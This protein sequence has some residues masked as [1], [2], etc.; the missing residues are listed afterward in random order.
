M[1]V[2]EPGPQINHSSKLKTQ[3]LLTD[4]FEDK[5]IKLWGKQ[6]HI[7]SHSLCS[8]HIPSNYLLLCQCAFFLSTSLAS[9]K[10]TGRWISI[11]L[12][13]EL[14]MPS[15][16]GI[17]QPSFL[18]Q[19]LDGAIVGWS[20]LVGRWVMV[21]NYPIYRREKPT[22]GKDSSHH[23]IDWL[24][25]IIS[26]F[27]LLDINFVCLDSQLRMIRPQVQGWLRMTSPAVYWSNYTAPFPL[28]DYAHPKRN[29][30]GMHTP[31]LELYLFILGSL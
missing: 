8:F 18:S 17:P 5:T 3:D 25:A 27:C 2:Q 6:F 26:P 28:S 10:K 19:T 9:D 23:A 4:H 24:Q 13:L 11:L 1:S 29:P 12:L 7:Y 16:V 15:G 30:G 14:G 21:P 31:D 20:K 22:M